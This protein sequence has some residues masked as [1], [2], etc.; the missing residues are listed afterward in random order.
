MKKI[1]A[2]LIILSIFLVKTYSQ[3]EVDSALIV[4]T[5]DWLYAGTADNGNDVW[6]FRR[7]YVSK[8]DGIIKIWLK[9]NTK[10]ETIKKSEGP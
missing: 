5:P 3:S 1:I 8:Q 6:H 2:T 9:V 7:T 4:P 10:S